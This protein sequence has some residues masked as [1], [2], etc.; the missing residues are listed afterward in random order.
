MPLNDSDK[1]SANSIRSR[2][3]DLLLCLL[4]IASLMALGLG[5]WT[6]RTFGQVSVDQALINL[7][8]AGLGAGGTRII[9]FAIIWIFVIPFI[10]ATVTLIGWFHWRKRRR[11]QPDRKIG[12]VT[13]ILVALALFFALPVSSTVVLASTFKIGDYVNGVLSSSD[14]GEYYVTPQVA[15]YVQVTTDSALNLVVI[16]LESIEDAMGDTNLFETNMLEPLTSR[17]AHWQTVPNLNQY[18]GGGWTMAGILSTQCGLPFRPP[19]GS[20]PEGKGMNV[21][22][23]E[24]ERFLPTS[25]CLGDVLEDLGYQNVFLGGANLDHGGKGTL[26]RDHGYDIALGRTE[27]ESRG[28]TEF[29][30]DWGLS[31]RR[32]LENAKQFA[33]EL[34]SSEKPFNLTLLTLDTHELPFAHDYCE[35][36][37]QVPLE[38]ITNCSLEEVGKFLDFLKDEGFMEDTV[39][40]LMGDHVK[41][42]SEAASFNDELL[43]VE[44]RTLFNRIWVPTGRELQVESIDQ[45][46]MYPTILESLGVDVL[47]G[48]AGLGVSAFR[49][50]TVPGTMR[51]LTDSENEELL[52]SRSADFYRKIW[53]VDR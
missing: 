4:V 33:E 37:T 26:F 38:S 47:D 16:Y 53:D 9:V 50:Q 5:R 23:S 35:I 51:D 2:L 29:R 25:V 19:P 12:R 52:N 14:L 34:R 3:I 27:W 22:G 28:E 7:Q 49:S 44:E 17:T 24:Q 31:D 30:D 8:G 36:T 1:H 32:L 42:I 11:E 43:Q 45:F 48:R 10:I 18:A 41:I 6:R 40:V 20:K 15:P 21:W 46:S 13:A 39:V